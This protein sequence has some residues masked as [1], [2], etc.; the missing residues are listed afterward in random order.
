MRKFVLDNAFVKGR[1]NLTLQAVVTW[2][3]ETHEVDVCKSTLSLWLHEMGFSYQQ[4]TK[5]VYFNE[6]RT[7][8]ALPMKYTKSMVMRVELTKHCQ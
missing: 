7:D 4:F 2:M 6:S 1:P 3:K 5:G 8:K